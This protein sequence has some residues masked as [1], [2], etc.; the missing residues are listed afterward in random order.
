MF[1]TSS[2][3]P[4][5]FEQYLAR[6]VDH[7]IG[8]EGHLDEIREMYDQE[9]LAAQMHPQVDDMPPCPGWCA[10][11]YGHRYESILN[12]DS[13]AGMVTLERFHTTEN[14]CADSYGSVGQEEHLRDGRVSYG[15]L[16]IVA[17]RDL[18]EITGEEARLRAA[19]L[20]KLADRLDEISR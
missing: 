20:V 4:A 12:A 2:T 6:W 11:D 8:V 3:F 18:E 10:L 16:H 5:T 9:R 15:P 1:P 17:G 19:E 7:G 14:L 13:D